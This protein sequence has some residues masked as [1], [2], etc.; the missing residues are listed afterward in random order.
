MYKTEIEFVFVLF[1]QKRVVFTKKKYLC[2]P[3]CLLREPL[4]YKTI[5]NEGV[6]E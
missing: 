3:L 5:I 6:V 4:W 2:E 1:Q